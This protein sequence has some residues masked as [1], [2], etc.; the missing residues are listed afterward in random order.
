MNGVTGHADKM[1]RTSIMLMH[2]GSALHLASVLAN[3]FEIEEARISQDRQLNISVSDIP[4]T[5]TWIC[6]FDALNWHDAFRF[7]KKV[8]S[9][10]GWILFIVLQPDIIWI[11]PAVHSDQKGCL[12]CFLT[13]LRN[14]TA[15]SPHWAQDWQGATLHRKV[16]LTAMSSSISDALAAVVKKKVNELP[17]RI[18]EV[19]RF[20]I[21]PLEISHHVFAPVSTCQHCQP[22]R[23]D[24]EESAYLHLR[25]RPKINLNDTRIQNPLLDLRNLRKR[26]VDRHVGI[27]RHIYLDVTSNLMP[28]MGAEMKITGTNTVERGFGRTETRARSELVAILET[29]ERYASHRPRGNFSHI[30]GSYAEISHRHPGQTLDPRSLILHAPEQYSE[31]GYELVQYDD[32]LE[33]DWCWGHSMRCQRPILVP[34]QSVYYWLDASQEKRENRFVYDSSNGCAIGGSVEEAVLYGLCEAVERDAYLCAWYGRLSQV[35]I[36]V[37]RIKEPRSRL[38]MDRAKVQGYEIYL[39]DI[40]SGIDFPIVWAMIVDPSPDAPV[41]SYCASAANVDWAQAVFSAL[42]E[43]TTSMSVYQHTALAWRPHA[44]QMLHDSSFVREMH[45]HIELYSIPESYSRL[46]F[47]FEQSGDSCQKHVM[48][49]GFPRNLDL[50]QELLELV[51]RTLVIAKDVVVVNLGFQMLEEFGLS[52]VKVLVPGLLPVTFGHQYRRVDLRRIKQAIR[53]RGGNWHSFTSDDINPYP[54]NFP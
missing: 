44:E 41:K 30:R 20:Q 38:L 40:R 18:D 13:R 34:K 16:S 17:Q 15:R 2:D 19:I 53:M 51:R 21:N 12:A 24:S 14:N 23:E 46:Q 39:F 32:T 11:G 3:V 31:P 26:F 49:A 1:E 29:L 54:H 27:I 8:L 37:D 25:P 50:T 6:A 43:V 52:A 28:M 9:L 48:T 5:S 45:H 35:L 7:Q 47:L 10:G 22:L 42:A 33:F 4:K 36:H